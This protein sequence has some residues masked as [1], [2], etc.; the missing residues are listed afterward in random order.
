MKRKE[1]NLTEQLLFICVIILSIIIISL[2][3]VLPNNLIPIYETNV[4]NYLKQPL[5]FLQ[6]EEDISDIVNTEVAYIYINDI[7][8]SIS[9]SDNLNRIIN[10]RNI[11]KLI[12]YINFNSNEGKFRYMG[13][14][15]YYVN[16][17]NNNQIMIALT[18]DSYIDSMRHSIYLTIFKVVGIAILLI[19]LFILVWAN[20]LVNRIKKIKDKIDNINNDRYNHDVS[21]NYYNDELYVLD[22]TV[23]D[24]YIY[25][26][27]KE[28]YKN[29][30]YQSI[31][32]DL[33][34]PITVIKSYIEAFEDG[35]YT[36]KKTL[37]V[38]KE[39]LKKLEI[40]VHS[41]LYLNKISY[42]ED[43]QEGLNEVYDVSIIV[44]DAIDKF[45][46]SR[47][48]VTFTF[49]NDKKNTIFRGSA[50]MWEAIIDNIL[51][52]FI[53]Y[54]KKKITITI[55]N[56]KI[57]LYN[58]GENIDESLLNNIFTPYKKGVNGVFGLGLSIVDKT[59]NLLD[60]VISIENVK[61][62]VKFI[63]QE[64]R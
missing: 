10:I 55:K 53:R 38:I 33:K 59:L 27:E 36:K 60:Y 63:I 41:L 25:L 22:K 39:Q 18:D 4:Y 12:K 13:S 31:S 21:H 3:I 47:P 50:D 56:N 48:D 58:D 2:G 26:K 14:T 20:N 61:N 11:S 40:K 23:S 46:V 52:N 30:M 15:Y 43:R 8:N 28:E 34:T 7:D 42:I 49:N 5:N 29:G 9:Y 57:I 64:R 24:M 17:I 44:N 51:G 54:A 45:K 19:C 6:N 32:H 1:V 35:V 37:E 62:G 16:S